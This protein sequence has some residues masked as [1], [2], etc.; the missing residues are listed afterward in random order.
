MR[1]L[2]KSDSLSKE[3]GSAAGTGGGLD[4]ASALVILIMSELFSFRSSSILPAIAFF[5]E[6]ISVISLRISCSFSWK[7]VYSCF[8]RCLNSEY[9]R[10]KYSF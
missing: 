5:T 8:Y 7:L 9:C 2:N 1:P 10:I 3:N 6:T 4:C